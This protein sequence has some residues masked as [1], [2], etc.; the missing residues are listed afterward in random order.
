MTRC[1]LLVVLFIPALL[2]L[3]DVGR[4]DMDFETRTIDLCGDRDAVESKLAGW[5]LHWSWSGL[6]GDTVSAGEQMNLYLSETGAE[7]A[8]A[9]KIS[10]GQYCVVMTGISWRTTNRGHGT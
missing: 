1:I 6:T 9:T 2:A 5:G 8:M 3:P 10:T 4:A 7:W